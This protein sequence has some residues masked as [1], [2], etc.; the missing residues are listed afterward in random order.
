ME[1]LL[2][3]ALNT[4]NSPQRSCS[5]RIGNVS[6]LLFV[7]FAKELQKATKNK[8]CRECR[9]EGIE[10]GK[11]RENSTK[12]AGNKLQLN[13]LDRPEAVVVVVL[14]V[15]TFFELAVVLHEVVVAAAVVDDTDDAK[16][17]AWHKN[18]GKY[19]ACKQLKGQQSK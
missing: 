8:E 17:D 6:Q 19:S 12:Q 10:L 13:F 4:T 14:I 3:S 16:E 7:L 18:A 5:N 1:Q 9:R 2:K 15:A 11:G